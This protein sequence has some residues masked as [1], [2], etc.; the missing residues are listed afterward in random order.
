MT[1]LFCNWW[2]IFCRLAGPVHHRE[3]VTTRPMLLHRVARRTTSGGQCIIT[4]TSTNGNKNAIS[5]FFAKLGAW[6]SAFEVSVIGHFKAHLR[7]CRGFL[8]GWEGDECNVLLAAAGWNLRTL[9]RILCAHLQAAV[10]A[11]DRRVRSRLARSC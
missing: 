11:L 3:A 2:S 7:L 8:Q 9:L 6:L 1:A 10:I 5:I 4:I